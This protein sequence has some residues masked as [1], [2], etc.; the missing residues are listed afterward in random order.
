MN[1]DSALFGTSLVALGSDL[2]EV[3]DELLR[4]VLGESEKFGRVQS[5]DMV[6]NGIRGLSEEV[7][8]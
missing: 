8:S 4:V 5:Q 2:L 3:D 1:P 6:S 7:A